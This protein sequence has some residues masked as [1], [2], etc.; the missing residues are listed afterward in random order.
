MSLYLSRLLQDRDEHYEVA[1]SW[2]GVQGCFVVKLVDLV[3]GQ[4][5][6]GHGLSITMATMDAYDRK[7]ALIG[8]GQ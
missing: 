8:E 1:L 4:E 2:D 7:A 5:T 6:A 3:T